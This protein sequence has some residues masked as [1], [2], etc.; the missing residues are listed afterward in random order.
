MYSRFFAIALFLALGAVTSVGLSWLLLLRVRD[1][2]LRESA[3]YCV[4]LE[5]TTW[6]E[7]S[8]FGYERLGIE[9]ARDIDVP[10]P[11]TAT[12]AWLDGLLRYPADDV[13]R[14]DNLE[15]RSL[16]QWCKLRPS[17]ADGHCMFQEVAGW[18][19]PCMACF[20]TYDGSTMKLAGGIQLSSSLDRQ[21]LGGVRALPVIPIWPYLIG[22]MLFWS[23]VLALTVA[24]VVTLQSL[25]RNWV[26]KQR[27][28]CVICGYDLR[29]LQHIR[30]PEC[31]TSICVK[32]RPD[33]LEYG[34]RRFRFHAD[35]PSSIRPRTTK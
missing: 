2:D 16:P 1:V 17:A 18:P 35:V 26:R 30:C 22:N 32:R 11:S 21:R 9:V 34:W 10:E 3:L 27:H 8:T 5:S 19:L 29:G 15:H 7:W 6:I 33:V 4:P 13:S 25:R 31:G 14:L 28:L 12:A 23:A 24:I 20:W